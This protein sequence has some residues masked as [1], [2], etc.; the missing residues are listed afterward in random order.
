VARASSLGERAAAELS[1]DGAIA[2]CLE[3]FAPRRGQAGMASAVG[4][5]I[6]ARGVLVCEAGTGTGKT[7]AY[8]VP[9]VLSGRRVIVSTATRTLQDQLFHRD[10]PMVCRALGVPARAAL[11]KGR[12]NYV[13]LHRLGTAEPGTGP[14]ARAHLAGLGRLRGWARTSASGDLAELAE[15][16]EDS[17]LMREV[18]STADNCLGQECPEI[19]RC[20]VIRA[21]QAA[22]RAELVVANHHLLL[23]DM[24]LRG[25]GLGEVLP[26]VDAIVVD[27]AHQLPEVAS[28]FFGE[29]LGSRQLA[30]LAR[31]GRRAGA[32][33][34]PDFPALSEAADA[35]EAAVRG[36]RDVLGPESRRLPWRDLRAQRDRSRALA[37]LEQG[38]SRITAAL[39][40]MAERG[41]ELAHCAQR[42]ARLA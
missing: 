42:A 18:T 10:L 29:A 13:C 35:L 9:A 24:A 19:G 7:L 22:A 41:S 25:E 27:E 26:G 30:E 36:L 32:R 15:L 16:P 34:A 37:A 31:D 21:R 33:E 4:Q 6:E 38:L 5:A 8:L 39:E 1:A 20:F 2:R 11:L 28:Q 14:L 40:A 12:Q 23:S 3:G 17:P